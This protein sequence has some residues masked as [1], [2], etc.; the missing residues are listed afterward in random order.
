V[1]LWSRLH[2]LSNSRRVLRWTLWMIVLDGIVLHSV[3][4]TLSFGSN[5]NSLSP[6]TL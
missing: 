3:T 2:L 4:T 5:S 1:V 6:Q